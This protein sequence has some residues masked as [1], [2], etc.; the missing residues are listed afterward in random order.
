VAAAEAAGLRSPGSITPGGARSPLPP[1]PAV[2]AAGGGAVQ[3]P[4]PE[5]RQKAEQEELAARLA[6]LQSRG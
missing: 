6:V 3:Q 1:R 4:S 2:P 5:E